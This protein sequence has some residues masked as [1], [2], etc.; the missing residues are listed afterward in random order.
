M[1][2]D[3][4]WWLILVLP[5]F[6]RLS[7]KDCPSFKASLGYNERPCLEKRRELKPVWL[8]L[9]TEFSGKTKA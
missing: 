7:L 9:W 8:R 3:P 5:A 2:Q 6:R 4:V 1:Y